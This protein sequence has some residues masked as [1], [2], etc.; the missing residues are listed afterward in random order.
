LKLRPI[1]LK[2]HSRVILLNSLFRFNKWW[3]RKRVKG[4]LLVFNSLFNFNTVKNLIIQNIKTTK[5]IKRIKN[6]KYFKSFKILKKIKIRQL[7]KLIRF[8]LKFKK[9]TFSIK[10][11]I[12]KQT[13]RN[14]FYIKIF[15]FYLKYIFLSI[16]TNIFFKL[17]P[18]T[19]LFNF[20]NL[21]SFLLKNPLF[22]MSIVRLTAAKLPTFRLRK[23]LYF[24][25]LLI[26]FAMTTFNLHLI[27]ERL[28]V[29]FRC[30]LH[31]RLLLS[32]FLNTMRLYQRLR[33]IQAFCFLVRGTVEK[34]GR[35][36]TYYEMFG[37]ISLQTYT[38]LV[39]YEYIQCW[40]RYG[41]FGLHIWLRYPLLSY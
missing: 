25:S 28:E 24:F 17:K 20:Q 14:W 11:K 13:F 38:T 31:K 39:Y 16:I 7:K 9:K 4:K 10:F 26:G 5:L 41:V 30:M 33:N 8:K 34:H 3:T 29:Y 2:Q 36:I 40:Q 19:F 21:E 23:Q 12:I 32:H 15:N 6:K 37:K 35:T 18:I 27:T 1:I 22:E